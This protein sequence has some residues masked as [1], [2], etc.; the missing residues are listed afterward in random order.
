M[1]RRFLK[2]LF[3]S[4][5]QG[6]EP[7]DEDLENFGFIVRVAEEVSPEHRL[8]RIELDGTTWSATSISEVIGAGERAKL[9]Y[10]DNTVWV[11]ERYMGVLEPGERDI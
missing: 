2:N 1:F 7:V 4:S 8:G 9:L 5:G 10:R 3:S 6:V 11:V